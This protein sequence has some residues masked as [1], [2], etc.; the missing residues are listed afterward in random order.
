MALPD[1]MRLG[2][3]Q[4]DRDLFA[5]EH[6]MAHRTLLISMSPL[7]RFGQIPYMRML[8]PMLDIQQPAVDWHLNHQQAHNDFMRVLPQSYGAKPVGLFIGGNVIDYNLDDEEQRQWWIHRNHTEH[9]VATGTISPPPGPIG[10]GPEQPLPPLPPIPW[11]PNW[12]LN[13]SPRY[14]YP[15]W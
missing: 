8:D 6:A 12:W 14:K 4:V 1:L 11:P 10:P 15:A 3:S 2:D 7:T 13:Q 9:Y 5:F